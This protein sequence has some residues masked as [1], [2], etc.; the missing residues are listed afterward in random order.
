MRVLSR[1][2]HAAGTTLCRVL[3]VEIARD[4]NAPVNAEVLF[5]LTDV[6]TRNPETKC[7]IKLNTGYMAH[8]PDLKNNLVDFVLWNVAC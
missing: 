8:P 2:A 4:W 5:V 6:T 3:N 7:D 1:S